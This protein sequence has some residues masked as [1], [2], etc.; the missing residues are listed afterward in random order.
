VDIAAPLTIDS[1]LS[2]LAERQH[3]VKL[4][5][6]I[7]VRATTRS[8]PDPRVEAYRLLIADVAELMGR[9]RSTSDE[10]ARTAGQT[11]ARWHLLSVLSGGPHSVA[12]AARRLGLARQS[13]QRVANDLLAEALVVATP[14]PG[15]ARAP[16]LSLTS[17]GEAL[18]ADLYERS[19][20]ARTDLVTRA[21]VSARQLQTA[22]ATVRA[23]IDAFDST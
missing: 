3:T 6:S 4:V 23:L 10:L 21:D 15:D 20:G 11:V 13:V 14:D 16:L 5:A 8:D 19:E 1:V 17:R 22:R 7:S 12:S 9:S 18:V 2:T